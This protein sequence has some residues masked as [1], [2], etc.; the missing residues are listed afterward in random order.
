[1]KHR[2]IIHA[3]WLLLSCSAIAPAQD[4]DT[5]RRAARYESLMIEAGGRY[6]V[7]PR[8]IWTVAYLETRFQPRLVSEAGACGLMQLMPATAGRFGV[9]NIFDPEQS[10]DAATR[11]L[12]VLQEMFA[13][14][15]DLILAA[16]NAGEGTVEAFKAGRRLVLSD[17]KVINPKAIKTEGVPPYRET[18]SYV[19]EGIALYQR[20][21]EGS[22]QIVRYRLPK[23][24]R[25]EKITAAPLEPMPEEII[26]LKQG[27]I[28]PVPVSEETRPDA[29]QPA[30]PY[31][32]H[33]SAPRSVY[34]R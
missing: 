34:P 9:K 13:G 30:A 33:N 12:R 14:R 8:L 20:L 27:S 19:S 6:G 28:Y 17:G 16:Y 10:I 5:L 21:I 1:M 29:Q 15:L 23:E 2:V 32:P 26:Q 18:H 25:E 4:R 11:Y 3:L 24:K 7:D 31:L 22:P